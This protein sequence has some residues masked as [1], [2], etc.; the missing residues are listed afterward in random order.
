MACT[1]LVT[2]LEHSGTEAASWGLVLAGVWRVLEA[3]SCPCPFP[4]P[5]WTSH[6]N[7][8]SWPT[9]PAPPAPC[10]SR[11]LSGFRAQP[12]WGALEDCWQQLAVVKSGPELTFYRNGE[13][14]GEG[15]AQAP[16]SVVSCRAE[17]AR[18]CIG[19]HAPGPPALQ[20]FDVTFSR[21]KAWSDFAVPVLQP[22]PSLT[23]PP[24]HPRSQPGTAAASFVVPDYGATT[25]GL[26]V[27]IASLAEPGTNGTAPTVNP[28][29]L[30]ADLGWLSGSIATLA[31]YSRALAAEDIAAAYTASAPRFAEGACKADA[32]AP[33]PSPAEPP[34]PAE[35]NQPDNTT[36]PA[37]NSPAPVD[38]TP[39][40]NA[41]T[42]GSPDT[43][44]QSPEPASPAPVDP[45]PTPVDPTASPAPVDPTASPG[46][47]DPTASPSPAVPIPS[48]AVPSPSPV[49][50]P[51][52]QPQPPAKS[53]STFD[54]S[55]AEVE[56]SG[57]QGRVANTLTITGD[58]ELAG[59]LTT[60]AAQ[61]DAR[62]T[63]AR[64]VTRAVPV[65]LPVGCLHCRLRER[66]PEAV[67]A[68]PRH[69]QLPQPGGRRVWGGQRGDQ[70]GEEGAP[71]PQ[72]GHRGGAAPGGLPGAGV[73]RQVQAR[74]LLWQLQCLSGLHRS[75][76]HSR[77]C[78]APCAPP[79]SSPPP[80]PQVYEW[81]VV[82]DYVLLPTPKAPVEVLVKAEINGER[83]G[84]W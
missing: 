39:S 32:A 27:E 36:E 57:T 70:G 56:G 11:P 34:A 73:G 8:C 65:L 17:A 58:D 75:A 76:C 6:R 23:H 53:N 22:C 2:E 30:D 80:L 5:R 68:A 61:A 71:P 50:S 15:A 12:T 69:C 43:T 24:T 59:G 37:E 60:P 55:T 20:L 28:A 38:P 74:R 41:T 45:S 78:T 81:V 21:A 44:T 63:D 16:T 46:P 48:P 62:C 10:S 52:P 42:P 14:A 29:A 3:G 72:G 79:P 26:G 31:V 18:P 13:E 64:H 25:I 51:V 35:P 66:C 82:C 54:N 84:W 47:V 9:R 67:R 4:A 77:S 1:R 40:D 33:A 49:P 7:L 83:V 19:R